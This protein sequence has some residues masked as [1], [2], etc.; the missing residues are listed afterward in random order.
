MSEVNPVQ[1]QIN[2]IRLY[3]LNIAI[4]NKKD[5]ISTLQKEIHQGKQVNRTLTQVDKTYKKEMIKIS[6]VHIPTSGPSK[7]EE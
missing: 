3:N 5:K 6:S 2:E 1:Q 7:A 4:A